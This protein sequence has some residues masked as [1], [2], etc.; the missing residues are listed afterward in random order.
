M[1]ASALSTFAAASSSN[2][3]SAVSV[4]SAREVRCVREHR[5]ETFGMARFDLV[6]IA[7]VEEGELVALCGGIQLLPETTAKPHRDRLVVH[8]VTDDLEVFW[9]TAVGHG[10]VR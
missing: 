4:V 5:L 6:V 1:T 9:L 2:S 7:G 3:A 8:A 10:G